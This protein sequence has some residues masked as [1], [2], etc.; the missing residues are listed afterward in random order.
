MIGYWLSSC[1]VKT[2]RD[3]VLATVYKKTGASLISL[4]SWSKHPVSVSLKID[5]QALGQDAQ[6]AKL[7]APQIPNF[8]NAASFSPTEKIPVE[9]AKGWLL[10]LQ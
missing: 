9:P 3:D 1:P 4:A 5:W 6:R 7:T 2:D 8:Q 10:I